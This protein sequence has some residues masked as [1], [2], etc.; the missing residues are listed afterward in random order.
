MRQSS[1]A[2]SL[3]L[4]GATTI[5]TVL[6]AGMCFSQDKAATGA[7][8]KRDLSDY[9]KAGPFDLSLWARDRA[10]T[11]AV[12]REWIWHHWKEK[13]LAHLVF[14]AQSIEGEPSKSLY[15]VEPDGAGGWRVSV[16]IERH[17]SD[18]RGSGRRWFEAV[19][20]DAFALEPVEPRN[21]GLVPYKP[22]GESED[23]SPQR[24]RLLLKDKKGKILQEL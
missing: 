6:T 21:S 24:Y 20:F 4:I 10:K 9:E 17:L 19:E 8:P 1:A 5:I 7:P 15:Y 11:E 23:V 3:S 18:R 16:R 14:N 12:I 13:R 22:I 2:T